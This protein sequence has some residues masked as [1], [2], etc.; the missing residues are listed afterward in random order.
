MLSN[1]SGVQKTLLLES[2]EKEH[3]SQALRNKTKILN[4]EFKKELN[5]FILHKYSLIE[6]PV[7]Y[8]RDNPVHEQMLI[9]LWET[10]FPEEELKSRVSPQWK[11]LGFQGNDPA[12]DFRGMGLLAVKHLLY[13]AT[14]YTTLLKELCQNQTDDHYYPVATAGINMSKFLFDFFRSQPDNNQILITHPSCL[15]EIYVTCLQVF[16]TTWAELEATYFDFTK[17]INTVSDK[18]K[19]CFRESQTLD[20]FQKI[21]LSQGKTSKNNTFKQKA[22][23]LTNPKKSEHS[24]SAVSTSKKEVIDPEMVKAFHQSVSQGDTKKVAKYLAMGVPIDCLNAEEQT[25]LIVAVNR[26]YVELVKFL[27]W[28]DANLEFTYRGWTPLHEASKN[29]TL[30]VTSFLLKSFSF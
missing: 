24:L 12:T 30:E 28:K 22:F 27:L 7:P 14:H 11:I 4:A 26:R 19:E 20:D 25:A 2:L 21:A 15:E 10:L 3:L 13:M 16:D 29:S 8:D 9:T 23:A 18:I 6:D 5:Q 1:S 17:V